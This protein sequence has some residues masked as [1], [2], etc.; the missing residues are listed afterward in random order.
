[1]APDRKKAPT[2]VA[3]S[4]VE[5]YL[6][7]DATQEREVLFYALAAQHE[8][9]A[10]II[11]LLASIDRQLQW[12]HEQLLSEPFGGVHEERAMINRIL[13]RSALE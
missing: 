11:A 9:R 10:R 8:Q 12:L 13:E 3:A 4:A 2:K 5:S 6:I 1:M 7:P